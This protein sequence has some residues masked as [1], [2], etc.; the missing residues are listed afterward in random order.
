M[1]AIFWRTV[2]DRRISLVAYL[3]AAVVFM[4]LYVA[5]FPS[6]QA[7]SEAFA[8]AFESIP[9]AFLTAFGIEDLNMTTIESFLSVEHFSMVWPIMAIL[10][11]LA[12]AGR[13]FAG[14]VEQGTVEILLSCPVSR[15]QIFLA[16]YLAG[17]FSLLVFTVVSVFSVVPFT[18][19]HNV[20]YVIVNFV[21][22]AAISLLFGWAILSISVLFSVVF[23]ERSRVYMATGGILLVMYVLNVVAALKEELADLR[24]MSFFHYYNYN[25]ALIRN[26]L[27]LDGVLVFVAAALV[28]TIVA[29]WWF[30]RRDIA[31]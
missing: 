31:V 18:A 12:I 3:V 22:V 10:L 19:L 28:C 7:Q 13:G 2:K 14:Q 23:S 15:I 21:S 26:Q 24:L 9:D 1:L 20:E 5:L 17:V 6:M 4:W 25:D 27:N 30:T 11:L 29:A 8:V 16:K